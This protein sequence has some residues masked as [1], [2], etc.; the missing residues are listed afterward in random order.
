MARNKFILL[1]NNKGETTA[2]NLLGITS[3]DDENS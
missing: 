3:L 2:K 1:N